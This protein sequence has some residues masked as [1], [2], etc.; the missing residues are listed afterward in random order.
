MLEP[1]A[2]TPIPVATDGVITDQTF[3]FSKAQP[4]NIVRVS[5]SPCTVS[6]DVSEQCSACHS[7]TLVFAF[8]A[9]G[10]REGGPVCS[11]SSGCHFILSPAQRWRQRVC[12][13]LIVLPILEMQ[14]KHFS[15]H[16]F[17]PRQV[18][19]ALAEFSCIAQHITVTLINYMNIYS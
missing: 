13:W 16:D 11:Q 7:E 17:C 15:V 2:G 4:F 6:R 14:T 9:A 19:P 8:V 10:C 12:T 1:T 5:V 18:T 3:V